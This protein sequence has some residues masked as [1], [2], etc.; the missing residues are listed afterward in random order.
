MLANAARAVGRAGG[1]CVVRAEGGGN[2]GGGGGVWETRGDDGVSGRL[3][4][5]VDSGCGSGYTGSGKHFREEGVNGLWP[6][7]SNM[8]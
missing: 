4:S 1:V 6:L 2:L 5:M 3:G 7:K 8:S